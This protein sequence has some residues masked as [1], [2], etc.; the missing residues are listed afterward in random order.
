MVMTHPPRTFLLPKNS[1]T[2][3]TMNGLSHKHLAA[4]K[5]VFEHRDFQLRPNLLEVLHISSVLHDYPF[6]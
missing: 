2:S 4:L 6:E 1:E 5:G 3:R